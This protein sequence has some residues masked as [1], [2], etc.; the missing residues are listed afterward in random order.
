MWERVV[1]WRAASGK[2]RSKQIKEPRRPIGE[3]KGGVKREP[4]CVVRDSRREARG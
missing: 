2:R 4:A 3:G 1:R